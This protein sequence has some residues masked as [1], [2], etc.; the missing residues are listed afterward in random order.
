METPSRLWSLSVRRN[1]KKGS[2]LYGLEIE[3]FPALYFKE[4]FM[5]ISES[6]IIAFEV[7]FCLGTL[8]IS[9]IYWG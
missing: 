7:G 4:V 3:R 6:V 9:L 8:V 5:D 2:I 1:C